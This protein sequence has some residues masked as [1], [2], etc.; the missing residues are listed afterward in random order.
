MNQP[1]FRYNPKTLR[2]ERVPFSVW[3][4]TGAFI[5]YGCFGFASFIGLNFAQNYFTET[6]L[7]KSLSAE[8]KSLSEYKVVL[9]SQVESSNQ[10]LSNLKTDETK[11]HEKLFEAPAEPETSVVVQS[12]SIVNSMDDW[13]ESMNLLNDRFEALIE[14][15]KMKNQFFGEHLTLDKDDVPTLIN[16]PSIAP[17]KDLNDQNLVSGFGIRI[18]PFHKRNYHHDGIDIALTKG[19]EVLAAG[20]GRV[21]SIYN[22]PLEAGFGNYIEIDHGN[23]LVTRYAHLE[24][25]S[26]AWGDRKSTRL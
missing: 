24:K 15:T 23:G 25:I 19:T 10:S 20:N 26:V 16:F 13:D 5:A 9:A 3:R 14:K 4:T 11:L 8:N 22:S 12:A 2:Y 17:V 7:E 21:I 18:N 1:Q 6:K